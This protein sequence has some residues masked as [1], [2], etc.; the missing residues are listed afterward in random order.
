MGPG[1][2]S[3]GVQSHAETGGSPIG[4]DGAEIGGKVIAR[5]LGGNPRLNSVAA[6]I[7]ILLPLDADL[8]I[9]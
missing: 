9:A 3:G 2:A 5:I 1:I 4:L 8:R 6:Q 7:D